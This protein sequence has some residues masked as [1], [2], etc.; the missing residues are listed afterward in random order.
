M[1]NKEIFLQAGGEQYH[2]IAALNDSEASVNLILDLI[3][4]KLN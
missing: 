1:T 2:Y 4:N 3:E